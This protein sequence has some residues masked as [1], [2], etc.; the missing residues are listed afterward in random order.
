M[1]KRNFTTLTLA[2]I[3][4]A[5]AI[6]IAIGQLIVLLKLP[7]YLDSIGT[8]LVGLLAGPL[9][10]LVA[11]GLT[12]LIWG[13]S[14]L[15]PTYT[16]FFYVAAVIGLLAGVFGAL[17][18]AKKIWLWLIGGLLTG[19][20]AAILSAPTSAIVFGGVTGAGTDLLVAALRASGAGIMQAT[21]GQGIVSDPIDKLVS[22]LIVWLIVLALPVR[23]KARFPQAD[24]LPGE[25]TVADSWDA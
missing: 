11:G 15:N 1:F 16:P 17:R 25:T 5:I 13:L 18:W 7:I 3:P 9:A 10:G 4:V 24:K 19:V 12:N 20:V 6:N 2:L 8:V 21:F 14:G 23:L 22:F